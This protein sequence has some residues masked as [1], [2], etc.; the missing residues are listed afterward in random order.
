MSVRPS[1]SMVKPYRFPY[2]CVFHRP[3]PAVEYYE[4]YKNIGRKYTPVKRYDLADVVIK[5]AI[6]ALD[7]RGG[8][9]FGK[10]SEYVINDTITWDTINVI[11][12]GEGRSRLRGT[13]LKLADNVNKDMFS[14]PATATMASFFDL[15]FD[16]NKEKQTAGRGIYAVETSDIMIMRCFIS[17]FK[18]SNVHL[19]APWGPVIA[20]SYIEGSDLNGLVLSNAYHSMIYG[21][22]FNWNIENG[23]HI[24]GTRGNSIFGNTIFKNKKHGIYMP[25]TP[26][27]GNFAI[28]NNLILA[29][30]WEESNVYSGIYGLAGT[31]M[32][33]KGNVIDGRDYRYATDWHKHAIYLASGAVDN[34]IEGNIIRNALTAPYINVPAGNIVRSN[35]GFVTVRRINVPFALQ[36]TDRTTAPYTFEMGRTL[37]NMLD[38][39]R[40]V[41]VYFEVCAYVSSEQTAEVAIRNVTDDVDITGSEMTF[42]ET[43]PTV[44][45]SGDI[46]GAL[47]TTDKVLAFRHVS[48]TGGTF[49]YRGSRLIIVQEE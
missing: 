14:I 25:A 9:V 19:T 37:F 2:S 38:W 18:S 27:P 29:N 31:F 12:Q 20:A 5:A 36:S 22:T 33:I 10:S 3:D 40:V 35:P 44:K 21:N 24:T 23:M 30:S 28:E 39:D 15:A 42:T 26:L 47:P 17:K 49:C 8:V 45:R 43:T 4:A 48:L 1:V 7:P 32:S 16:G 13:C 11:L 46:K 6:D 34:V 41:A